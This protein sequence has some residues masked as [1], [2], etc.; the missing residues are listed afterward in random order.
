[1]A[2]N[3][4]I[5]PLG[6]A[7]KQ[8]PAEQPGAAEPPGEQIRPTPASQGLADPP[9]RFLSGTPQLPKEQ[10]FLQV[11]HSLPGIPVLPD[12]QKKG[13]LT[14]L[15]PPQQ[16]KGNFSGPNARQSGTGNLSAPGHS[17]P[18]NSQYLGGRKLINAGNLTVPG[19][20]TAS[21]SGDN[22]PGIQ[23]VPRSLQAVFQSA[24]PLPSS[25][26]K[27]LQKNRMRLLPLWARIAIGLLV[28]LL[29]VTGGVF[30]YYEIEI[31][32]SLNNILGKQALHRTDSQPGGQTNNQE[33]APTGRTNILLLGSDT[34]GKGNDP[35]NGIPLAQTVMII[36]VDPQTNYVGMLSIPRDMQVTESGY[37]EPKLDEVFSHGYSGHNLQDKVAAGAGEMEDIIQ[38]NFG[39]HIDHYAWVG[40]DGFVKVINT[41]GGVDVDA[42]HPMVDDSYPDDVGNTTGSIYDY[43]RLYI[44]PGP[45]HLNGVQALE[46]VRT[47]HSDLIGDFGRTIRQQQV[48][49]QLKVKLATSDSVGK[50]SELLQDLN[51][52]VQT[53]MQLNDVIAL[54]NLARGIDGNRVQ[55]LTLGPPDYA[56]PNTYGVRQSNYLP[57]CENIV[58]AIQKMFNIASPDCISQF[59]S[60]SN[61]IASAP[62]STMPTAFNT[63]VA[64]DSKRGSNDVLKNNTATNVENVSLYAGVR[65]LLA[66]L[67]AT[68]F[69]SFD[70]MQI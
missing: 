51:G 15:S 25:E 63:A 47:R 17:Y 27:L 50:A 38:N 42:I 31:A 28:F 9:L 62:P 56:V 19:A 6:I 60:K 5:R 10:P 49:N 2:K 44:A 40:L 12:M 41:A 14:D 21:Y 18:G 24:D 30:A 1:M 46:Y 70:P 23:R 11:P 64:P 7:K 53:D 22:S 66:V 52:A 20:P 67:F 57:R 29:I 26:P 34:D 65:A 13:P 54:G 16:S 59:A 3:Q 45:Q 36:T 58:P 61:S 8:H 69:E 33:T 35:N 68:T 32:P 39:I 4:F 43:K 48:I 55:R 37:P